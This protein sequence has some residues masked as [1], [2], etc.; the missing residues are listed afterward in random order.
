MSFIVHNDYFTQYSQVL[1]FEEFKNKIINE[2]NVEDI[3]FISATNQLALNFKQT[4]S[5]DYFAKKSL[6]LTNFSISNL[7]GIVRQA[8][9]YFKPKF[10]KSIISD[11]Y[12]F[13]LFKEAFDNANLKFF[14]RNNEK[15]SLFVIKWLSQIIFGLKE[16]GITVETFDKEFTDGNSN[17]VNYAKFED[18]RNL[19]QSYQQLLTK[20]GFVDIIEAFYF[21]TEVLE[22]LIEKNSQKDSLYLPFLSGKKCLILFGFFDFKIPEINFISTLSKFKNPVAIYLD[23]D[24]TNGPLFGN[25]IDLIIKF[26]ERGLKVSGTKVE[27][28]ETNTNFLKKY[29]FNNI[30]KKQCKSLKET[31]RI[32][33]TENRYT[34]AKEI[35]KLCKYL[36]LRMGY[37]P[38]EICITTKNPQTYAELF[39]ETFADANIP[40]NITERFRL[41]SSPLI[42]AI[43]SALE[44]VSKGFRFKDLRKVLLSF[45]FRF[46][47]KL[48]QEGK[49][50]PIDSENFLHTALKMKAI[51]GNELGG[52]RYW[53]TRFENRIKIIRNRITSLENLPYSDQTE[54]INLKSE[55]ISLEKAYEDFKVLA[56]YFNFLKPTLTP[57]EF[58][59]IIIDD[60]IN[61]F[62]VLRTLQEVVDGTLKDIETSNYY[63]KISRIEELE[64]DTRALSRFL[65]LLEEFTFITYIRN[66]NKKFTF[67]ELLELLRVVIFEE[68]YQISRKSN[69]GV[70]ITS[71]EQ[72]R[73]IP[74]KVMILCGAVDGEFPKKY[75][76]QKFLGK[77]LGKSERRHYENER[78]EFF[79]FLTNNSTLFDKN[80]RLTYI[81]YPKQDSKREFVPS[82]FIASLLDLFERDTQGVFFNLRY[83]DKLRNLPTDMLWVFA[84]VTKMDAY[85]Y[86]T[87]NE[88]QA[89]QTFQHNLISQI[90]YDNFKE[91]IL[92]RDEFT[93]NSLL[94][95]NKQIANPI[96]IS[97]LEEYIR[98]PFKFFVEKLLKISKKEPEFNIFLTNLEKGEI[99]HI[100]VSNFYKI[101]AKNELQKNASF[102]Y[103]KKN[104]IIYPKVK[105]LQE[106]KEL[107]Y[108]LL[109]DITEEILHKFDTELSLFEIDIEEFFSRSPERIGLAELWLKYELDRSNWE[110]QPTFFEL[111]FGLYVK[112]SLQ[113]VEIGE[114][115]GKKL[116]MQGKIDR[117]DIV[118]TENGFDFL[119]IDYK[120]KKAEIRTIGDAL[121]GNFFQ[122]PLLGLAFEKIAYELF[123]PHSVNIN[124]SY[125][126]FDY[127][128]D[129]ID[130]SRFI[131]NYTPF[132]VG[133]D[134]HFE[135]IIKE[136]QKNWKP[137]K[138]TFDELKEISVEKAIEIIE[139]IVESNE[140]P[141]SPFP[142]NRI[143]NYCSFA[144][145]CKIEIF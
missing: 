116:K 77:E 145:I 7:E 144:P 25:Y 128:I 37:K 55:L 134:S 68:R 143:C 112:N 76:P 12:R 72:T 79:F 33:E 133:R 106:N 140:F 86:E 57:Q 90:Y 125:Q 93:E 81:F 5:E 80:K 102:L 69:Y 84:V 91:N 141:V 59:N 105:L 96:S 23:F 60:I 92:N 44:V 43:I 62:G 30:A 65:Q 97:Y 20:S 136:R 83:L 73:G 14:R 21:V 31:I 48:E 126:I 34:E 49:T 9:E 28:S 88:S 66:K 107:Y 108:K 46:E 101:L 122:M 41:S 58:Q 94:L 42:I 22:N 139:K 74:Y 8:Y 10:G 121:R 63:D 100:I 53:Q 3:Y 54:I 29:L 19:F 127:K 130:K 120:L 115:K 51:G 131:L 1:T 17:I 85:E 4:F 45:Y 67:T 75:S 113:P 6:P 89:N 103:D 114:F 142:N 95:L 27:P 56:G 32:C 111:S 119:L 137:K 109:R 82:P 36:I 123:A 118:E 70:N 24:E 47:K 110:Y 87:L 38:N 11:A 18:T 35:A 2:G 104:Q 15:V 138:L 124:L 117:I 99:L 135:K 64:R 50:Q 129:E 40:V 98:C 16:D 78:L 13:L 26:K 52:V 61:K 39:R 71:I 132:L